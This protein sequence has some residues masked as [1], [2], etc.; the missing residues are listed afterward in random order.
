VRFEQC[1][2]VVRHFHLENMRRIEQPLDML[3][4]AENGRAL[5]RLVGTDTLENAHAVVQRMGQ[6]VGCC[7]TPWDQFPI[8]PDEAVAIRHGHD[9][10]PLAAIFEREI[11]ADFSL[12][13]A[14]K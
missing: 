4:Q 9:F 12:R 10:S 7:L 1:G 8:V 13:M 3:M 2:L 14:V 11:L 6:Y 5:G